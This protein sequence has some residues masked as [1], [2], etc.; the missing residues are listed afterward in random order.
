VARSLPSLSMSSRPA[1]RWVV[2]ACLAGLCAVLSLWAW[3]A[4]LRSRQARLTHL[5]LP[6]LAQG[7]CAMTG[8]AAQTGFALEVVSEWVVQADLVP[9]MR[10]FIEQ[11]WK[12]TTYMTTTMELAVQSPTVVHL[13][14]VQLRVYRGASLAYTRERATRVISSTSVIVC[15]P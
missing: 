1:R 9:V 11:G 14:P 7:P 12:S 4:A 5:S 15:P 8:A 13:G 10:T 2:V 6:G 3:H